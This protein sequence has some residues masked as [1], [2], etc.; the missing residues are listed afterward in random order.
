MKAWARLAI[1][2]APPFLPLSVQA[3]SLPGPSMSIPEA[4]SKMGFD[5]GASLEFDYLT[6]ADCSLLNTSV[7]CT[8]TGSSAFSI[9]PAW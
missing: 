8:S 9:S 3:R 4:S 5:W 6:S 1:H 7:S 2:L